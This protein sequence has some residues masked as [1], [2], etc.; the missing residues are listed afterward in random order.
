VAALILVKHAMPKIEPE[1]PAKA[2][3]LSAEGR[4]E[5]RHLSLDLA[6]HAPGTV[7]A[8]LE[9][10]ALETGEIV[11]ETLSLPL[12]TAPNLHEHERANEPFIAREA[13]EAKVRRFFERPGELVFGTETAQA[14]QARFV[15]AVD[16][17]LEHHQGTLIIVAHGTVISLFA[18]AKAGLEP[19]SLWQ[20]LGLP[21]YLAFSRPDFKLLRVV[22][23]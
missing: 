4:E 8:S 17:L 11:A 21:S 16:G 18:Q 9:P 7:V 22:S 6:A 5:A 19:F 15:G 14:A 13:F 12:S 20:K 10:K 1:L 23:R 3:R 2:W